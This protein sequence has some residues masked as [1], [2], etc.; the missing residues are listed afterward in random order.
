MN[1]M[2]VGAKGL[3]YVV[4]TVVLLLLSSFSAWAQLTIHDV[5]TTDVTSSGFA[6]LWR[7]SAAATPRIA[8]FADPEETVEITNKLEVTL[9]PLFG[10]DPD[11]ADEF[12][13]DEAMDDLRDSAKSLGLVKI[14]V[15]GCLPQTPYYFRVFSE[16]AAEK[17][18]WPESG[19]VSV[20][21][22]KENAFVRD[23]KQILVT[24]RDNHGSIDFQGWLM[25]AFA[26]ETLYPVSSYVGDGGGINQAYLDLSNL[27]DGDE[28]NW[29]P[30]GLQVVTLEV[31]MPGAGPIR[32]GLTLFYSETFQVGTVSTVEINIDEAGDETPPVVLPSIPGGTYNGAQSITLS[33]DEQAY[34][35]FTTDD[36]DPT[37]DSTLYTDP[38]Q[39]DQTTTLKFLAVDTAG[40]QSVV[41]SELYT[42]GYNQLPFGPTTPDPVDEATTISVVTALTWQSQGDPDAGDVVWYDVYLWTLANSDP[43]VCADQSTLSCLPDALQ[44][45]TTYSWQVVAKDSHGGETAGPVWTFATF[46]RNGD[47]DLDGLSNED[48]IFWGSN[49]FDWDTDKDGY[50]DGDEI[51]WGSDPTDDES[52]PNIDC[53]GD[54]NFDGDVDAFDL[55]IFT[56]AIG[57]S[58]GFARFNTAADFD[59][60]D[61]VDE[62]DLMIFTDD[63]GRVDCPY[64][65]SPADLD[66]DGDVDEQ[67]LDQ[68]IS[69]LDTCEGSQWFMG[70][71][72]YDRNGC[73]TNMDYV[74]WHNYYQNQGATASADVDGDGDVDSDDFQTLENALGQCVRDAG[75]V[76]RADYDGDGC[77]TNSDYTTWY[78]YYNQN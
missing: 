14:G 70:E 47:E 49:P 19:L 72:D 21:T 25:T 43:P 63:Y 54:F 17:A 78:G 24:L 8:V 71:A 42:I 31:R 74:L 22:K 3:S 18:Q 10:G 45:D 73:I 60:D 37:T 51:V 35:F 75:F 20:I 44:F 46:S 64:V 56:D 4:F 1:R 65:L 5:Q 11:I 48:E 61:Q 62:R 33:A 41:D 55:A 9:F 30:T 39:I 23:S 7:N 58:L 52:I 53:E 57:S 69:A 50:S 6:V 32:R 38:I 77:I 68:F 40:N 34:I 26:G 67:D 13:R 16:T 2:G 28:D 76:L 59:G 15:Q 12:S 36:S 66:G 27:F 29:T